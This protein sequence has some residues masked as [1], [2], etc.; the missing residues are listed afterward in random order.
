[1]RRRILL[2]NPDTAPIRIVLH[3]VLI[4]V[5]FPAHVFRLSGRSVFGSIA[6]QLPAL[7]ADNMNVA[8]D[9]VHAHFRPIEEDPVG[10]DVLHGRNRPAVGHGDLL[11]RI[12]GIAIGDIEIRTMQGAHVAAILTAT[13]DAEMMKNGCPYRTADSSRPSARTGPPCCRES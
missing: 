8:E 10:R 1:M 7:G 9:L 6:P 11:E 13:I 3:A 4:E 5:W 2:G 12:D